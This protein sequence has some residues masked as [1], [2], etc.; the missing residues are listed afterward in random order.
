MLIMAAVSIAINGNQYF[1][2]SFFFS[3]IAAWFFKNA[4]DRL[5]W[6]SKIKSHNKWKKQ[7]RTH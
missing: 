4:L 1:R 6:A 7:F 3:S 5:I 2:R